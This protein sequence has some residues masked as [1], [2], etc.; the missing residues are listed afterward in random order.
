M[1]ENVLTSIARHHVKEASKQAEA[2]KEYDYSTFV[3]LWTENIELEIAEKC[4]KM[5]VLEKKFHAI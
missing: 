2:I 5:P 1:H 4:L 3:Y